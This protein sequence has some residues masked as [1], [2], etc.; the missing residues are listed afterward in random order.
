[1]RPV[2]GV[3]GVRETWLYFIQVFSANL[4]PSGGLFPAWC[5]R[6]VC[7]WLKCKILINFNMVKRFMV[8][9]CCTFVFLLL[10]RRNILTLLFSASYRGITFSLQAELSLCISK[11]R[12]LEKIFIRKW[13][14]SHFE[15]DFHHGRGSRLILKRNIT[16]LARWYNKL[17]SIL[18]YSYCSRAL[19][20]SLERLRGN[21]RS[22]H[23]GPRAKTV[24]CMFSITPVYVR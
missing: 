11:P 3:W 24:W 14:A 1:M 23:P 4:R 16:A 12:K 22:T 8:N 18:L 2:A 19:S 7:G 21:L 17:H 6:G 10:R 9:P 20:F 13:E 15:E 5:A